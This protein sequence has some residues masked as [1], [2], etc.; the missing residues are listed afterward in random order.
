M[1]VV[2]TSRP[3][4]LLEGVRYMWY[5]DRGRCPQMDLKGLPCGQTT[6]D[7]GACY[8]SM[9]DGYDVLEFGFEDAFTNVS[10]LSSCCRPTPVASCSRKLD[11][12]D[13]PFANAPV[14][15]L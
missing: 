8:R 7:P 2:G 13:K 6:H 12:G 1:V 11:A 3:F 15:V 9:A 14:E 5:V 4:L 10:L